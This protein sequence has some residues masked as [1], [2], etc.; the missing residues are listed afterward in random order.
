MAAKDTIIRAGNLEVV[1]DGSGGFTPK[2]LS[3]TKHT[4][5]AFTAAGSVK[6][7]DPGDPAA[8]AEGSAARNAKERAVNVKGLPTCKSSGQLQARDTNAVEEGLQAGDHRQGHDRPSRSSSPNRPR[9]R[10]T[11]QL[12]VFN[13]GVKGGVTTFYIHAYLTQ[14]IT[15]A[16]VTTVKIK[17]S[18]SGRY[19]LRHARSRKSPTAPA[20]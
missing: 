12:L 13:G 7:L 9:S 19:E 10:P 4:P 1:I 20:R 3:K 16:I 18:G 6:S 11:A 14:P 2:A 5:I 15:A 8:A 17:K